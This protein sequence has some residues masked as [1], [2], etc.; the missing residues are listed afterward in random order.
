M[1]IAKSQGISRQ[2]FID[3]PTLERLKN[4]EFPYFSPV[5][6]YDVRSGEPL[7]LR[8]LAIIGDPGL[9]RLRPVAAL[10]AED[11]YQ[12]LTVP[13]SS[14]KEPA[15]IMNQSLTALAG[16]T[17]FRDHA[18]NPGADKSA[19]LETTIVD[20]SADLSAL[21]IQALTVAVDL[22]RYV[23]VE[24][25]N[26][27]HEQVVSLSSDLGKTTLAKTLDKAGQDGRIL[28]YELLYLEGL[29]D[30]IGVAALS[31]QLATRQPIAAL[32]RIQT[33]TLTLPPKNR[34]KTATCS[35]QAEEL[36]AMRVLGMTTA[37]FQK[38]KTRGRTIMPT[39][40]TRHKS[41]P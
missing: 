28:K 5:M 16:R 9:T 18:K 32:I 37:T 7:E 8:M 34:E 24:T 40:I 33:E 3:P 26:A 2:D 14:P 1:D 38:I 21:K 20:L 29:S 19:A 4:S 27:V 23:P 15:C 41:L 12:A 30:Q 10:S 31:A 36:Q 13:P 11:I 6:G 22:R 35:M 25:Y 17:V 39:P